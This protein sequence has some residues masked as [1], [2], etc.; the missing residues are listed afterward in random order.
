MT[1]SEYHEFVVIGAGVGGLQ[2]LTRLLQMGRDVLVI[3]ANAGV[4]GTWFQNRYPGCRFDSESFTYGYSFSQE[5]LQEWDWSEMFAARPETLRYLEH[6]ADRF[7]LR[8]HIRF[9]TRVV[10]ARYD[11]PRNRWRVETDAGDTV[12]CRFL[13]TAV[14]NLSAPTTPSLPGA[15]TFEGAMFHTRDWPHDGLDLEGAR[16]AVVG[17]GATGIQVISAIAAQVDR[18]T[19][20]QRRPN[21]AAP[22]N[23]RP[24][25]ADEMAEIKSRYDEIFARCDATPGGFVHGP[26]EERFA[27]ADPAE[28]RALWERLYDAPGFGIWLGNYREVLMD[29]EANAELSAFVADKIRQRVD[30]PA[31]AEQL[32]P[33]DHG[34]GVQRLPLETG[35]YETYNRPNVELVDLSEEPLERAT[36]RGVVVGGREIALDVIV[37]A[38]GFDAIVGALTR[39]DIVGRDG[40]ALRD[41]WS[42]GPRT[43]Y[44]FAVPGFPNLLALTGPL[45]ASG[46]TN[47]PRAIDTC[48]T[49]VSDLVQHMGDHG[50]TR[51][52]ATAE[53][54]DA[55]VHDVAHS[56]ERLLMRNARSWFTGY[57]TNLRG[58]EK[59]RHL[60]YLGGAPRFRER[61]DEVARHGYEG[62]SL[63][64]V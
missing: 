61:I 60:M 28:R 48:V 11:E 1:T 42:S 44:G 46:A 4:G 54:T 6:V 13:I 18:L 45:S 3:E 59:P 33:R 16:V 39:I 27:D 62:F 24:I 50:Y 26:V 25:G 19:V 9:D 17:T 41:A 43:A 37:F 38:T 2:Q 51:I 64:R 47:F 20:L 12:E 36:P 23:N 49:W 53:A 29:P 7:E 21:W 30:D 57:N 40:L 22:L 5:L 10:A 56:H 31:T 14:G 55:W 34:F 32:I 52:E 35:Y 8:P 63:E 58:T 15:D